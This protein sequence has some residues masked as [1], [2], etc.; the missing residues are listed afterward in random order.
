MTKH[1]SL[2]RNNLDVL[3]TGLRSLI[4]VGAL[5][6]GPGVRGRRASLNPR[7]GRNPAWEK[8]ALS[9]TPPLTRDTATAVAASCWN[10]EAIRDAVR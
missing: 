1:P 2:A 3:H 9:S 10:A 4:D 6:A 8:H 7:R 5:S